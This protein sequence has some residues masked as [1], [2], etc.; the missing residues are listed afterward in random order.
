MQAVELFL[1]DRL[2]GE[3]DTMRHLASKGFRLGY[4][5]DPRKE[6]NYGVQ[7]LAVDL[8]NG[9]RLS[10]LMELVTGTPHLPTAAML[11]TQIGFRDSF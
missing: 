10:K 11:S 1:K 9:L 3:G 4:E 6:Y 5:Q 2:H 8:R 7:N